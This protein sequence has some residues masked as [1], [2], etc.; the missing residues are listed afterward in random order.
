[1][2]RLGFLGQEW[3]KGLPEELQAWEFMLKDQGRNW[4]MSEYEFRLDPEAELQN[5]Y[6]R[7][8]D[9]PLGGSPIKLLDVGAGP[10]TSFGKRWKGRALQLFPVD[11]LADEYNDLLAKLGLR[12]PTPSQPGHGE[13]L[14]ELFERDSFDLALAS[15]SLDHSYDPLL[16]IRHMLTLVKPGC[17]VFLG[18]FANEAV[19]AGY[20]GLHQWNFSIKRNDMILSDGRKFHYSLRE[21]F[22]DIASLECETQEWVGRP[23]VIG[24]LKKL[25]QPEQQRV[26]ISR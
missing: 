6:K 16:V 3:D 7:L 5:E 18:H 4:V 25:T 26:P 2:R 10:L 11:P 14:L 22:R 8:I 21:E 20:T 15:N 13:K 24:R 12:S 1:M 17:Y 19:T 9:A 23:A